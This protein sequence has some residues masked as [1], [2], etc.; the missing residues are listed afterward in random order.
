MNAIE[1]NGALENMREGEQLNAAHRSRK[2][3]AILYVGWGVT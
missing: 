1:D 3:V 2:A